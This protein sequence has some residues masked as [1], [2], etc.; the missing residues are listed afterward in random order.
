MAT[1]LY[2]TTAIHAEYEQVRRRAFFSRIINW[3]RG[4]NNGLLSL[5]RAFRALPYHA[6]HDAGVQLVRINQI[7][8][9]AG[10]T[11]DFDRNFLPLRSDTMERWLRIDEAYHEGVSLPPVE[12]VKVGNVYFVEDG[13]HRISVARFWHQ[14]FIEAHVIEVNTPTPVERIE[15]ITCWEDNTCAVP[16]YAA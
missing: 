15:D 10:R 7:V 16:Q 2:T 6:R 8:G 13:H 4:R 11:D 5:E 9:S 12:L 1:S 3:L 14:E